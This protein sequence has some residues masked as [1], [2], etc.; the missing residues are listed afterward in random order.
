MGK[1]RSNYIKT[2]TR[3][4]LRDEAYRSLFTTDFRTNQQA[5]KEMTVQSKGSKRLRNRIAG[6][7]TRQQRIL[8][9][10]VTT[11]TDV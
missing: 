1:I 4:I 8:T 10:A 9:R 7:L 3:E 2:T 6:Y 5:L 11:P